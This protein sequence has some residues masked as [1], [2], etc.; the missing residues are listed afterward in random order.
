MARKKKEPEQNKAKVNT[1]NIMGLVGSTT[2]QAIS[3]TLEI[4]YMPYAMSVIVSRAIPEIDG[5]KPSHRKLLYTMYKMGLLSGGRTK[6]ANIVGQTMRLNPHGDAAIYETMVRL[7]RGNE[8]LLHP[9]VDSKGNF[10]KVYSRDMAYAAS[11]YTEAK[12]EAFCNELFRDIDSDTVD[13]VDNYDATMKEPSLLPT[14][15]PTVLVSANQG[16]AVGM[17]SNICSF[18]LKEVCDTTI[19]LMNNPDHDILSTLPGPDFS[20]GAELL[21]DEATTRDIYSTGRGSFKLRAKWSYVKADNV[22]EITEIPYSTTSEVIMDKVAELIKAGKIKEIADMRD[23]TDLGGLKLTID[24]KRGVEPEKLM[25]K[26]FRMT[27][28]QD[29]F[30]CNFNILIAGMPRVMGVGEILEEWTAWRTDCIKRRLFFQIQKKQDRLHL[31]KG[32]ERILLDIDKAIRI[33]RETE[34]ESE[35]VPNLM[36]GFGID[37]IQANFVAE[38]KLRNINKEYILKQT[39]A[40][41]ELEKEIADLQDT[42]NS[43]RKLKNVIIKEL[44]QVSEK[45]GKPR[46]T[47]IIYETVEAK[48]EDEEEQIP[49]YPVTVFVSKEGY[50]KKITPQSLRMSGEQKFKEGD[51]LSF[52]RETSNKAELLVF[53]SLFQ[54]Y[55]TRLSDFDDGKA[56]QLG[57]YLPQKL[58]MDPGETV[59]QVLMPGDYKGF[60]LFFFEN[61]KAAKVPLSAYE[62]KTNRRRLTG[63]FS[64]KSPLV[65]AMVLDEDK[66][67]V[68]YSSDNRAAIISTAQLTPKTTRNTIGVAV[69]SLKKK[70]QLSAAQLLEESSITN[71]SRYRNKTI[72][73]A[74]ALLKD[75]DAQ[76]KQISFDM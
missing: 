61:G 10:G 1:D 47:E 36:I 74:G 50:L 15:F 54:C 4:N 40:I 24:L 48:V 19:A 30:P 49:D 25:Q 26:L 76:E 66:Q 34:L 45:Y 60:V 68:L 31:L 16:I 70:A 64:D 29:S 67:V 22:I 71:A 69:M 38:I 11:R 20:T 13:M 8:T 37:E 58:G 63:A 42:L 21:F 6:S 57:D 32:L 18:N 72:P 23:E 5:F 39:K 9:F 17:A 59:L 44:Q 27:P 51:S 56:S 14:T 55:K 35:V 33:I 65:A 12:L 2:E 62:T 3:E 28:L 43:H 46:K 52:S 75:E 53:T 73:T 7:A 41:D